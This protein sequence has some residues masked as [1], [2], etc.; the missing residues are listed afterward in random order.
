MTKIIENANLFFFFF[1]I[2]P[3]CVTN[4]Q[5]EKIKYA[6]HGLLRAARRMRERGRQS[7]KSLGAV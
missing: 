5:P 2:S 3:R 6:V 4:G 7:R 1:F